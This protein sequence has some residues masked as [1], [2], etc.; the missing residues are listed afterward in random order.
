MKIAIIAQFPFAVLDGPMEGRAAGHSATWLPQLATS[1]EA[2]SLEIHWFVL[3][4]KEQ[5]ARIVKKWGQTFH[6]IPCPSISTSLLLCRWPQR[7]AFRKLYKNIKP[8]II[9]CW[10]TENLFGAALLDFYGPSILSMQGVVST[11]YKTGDLRGWRWKLFRYWEGVSVAKSS[12]VTAES[13]WGI[14]Q[15]LKID[16]SKATRRIEYGVSPGYY[17]IKWKPNPKE[18]RIFFAGSLNRLKGVDILIEMLK[19]YPKRPWTLVFAGDGYFRKELLALN[20]ASVEVLGLL[21]TSEIQEQMSRAWALVHPSRADTSPNVVKEARVI[22]LPVIGSPNGG[23]A[24]YIEHGKDGLLVETED[25]SDW[26]HSLDLICR[27]FEACV[28]MGAANHSW[29]QQNF[30]PEKTAEQ[31]LKLYAEMLGSKTAGHSV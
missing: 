3:G 31:F 21:K 25:P 13:Q 16:S 19:R 24:E 10:G 30:R 17:E 14:N 8:D 12:I 15:V 27:D 28:A 6:L 23:H 20:D 26:F 18:P 7:F 9:H 22:G 29:F 4:H 11:C 1:F 5:S 2:T